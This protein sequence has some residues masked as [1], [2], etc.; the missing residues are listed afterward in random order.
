MFQKLTIIGFGL[1]GSSLAKALRAAGHEGHICCGDKSQEVCDVVLEH[2]LADSATTESRR[3]QKWSSVADPQRN[4]AG[5]PTTGGLGRP[6]SNPGL[7]KT[8]C[9]RGEAQVHGHRLS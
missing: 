6:S 5:T 2:R 8:P 9:R 4:T 1:I 3:G 7:G